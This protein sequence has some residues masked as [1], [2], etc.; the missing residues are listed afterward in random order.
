VKIISVDDLAKANYPYFYLKEY[1]SFIK[2]FEDKDIIFFSD[3]FSN[4][5]ACKIWKN[6]FLKIIQPIYPPLSN[7]AERMNKQ[8]ELDFLNKWVSFIKE[9]KM[10]DRIV[11]SENFGIFKSAPVHSVSAPFG[12]YY[13]NLGSSTEHE[14]FQKIHVKHRNVIRNAE[15]NEIVLKYGQNCIDDF[16]LLYYQTMKRSNMYCQD[17]SYFKNLYNSIPQNTICRV[18]Y[19]N[20]IP[21]GGIFMP[22]TEFGAFYLYGASTEKIEINGTINYLHW[23]TIKVLKRK[24]VKRYDFVGARLSNVSGTKLAG[25]QQFKRRFG[26]QLEEGFLWKMNLSK[27]KC[28]IYDSLLSVKIKLRGREVPLDII[29][30]ENRKAYVK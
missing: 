7:N 22:F 15:K 10:A 3:E 27:K 23:N 16:Y 8:Q 20:N 24:N 26:V 2:E 21:Q 5:I 1:V 11:Q 28:D 25:I 30:Q 17:V 4:T 13:L 19:F 29:D 6:K 9:A 14:L 18:A 12:T